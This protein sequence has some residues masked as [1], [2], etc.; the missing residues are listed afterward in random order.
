MLTTKFTKLNSDVMS[1]F[2]G[3]EGKS[4]SNEDAVEQQEAESSAAAS[5]ARSCVVCGSPDG[6]KSAFS[7]CS[8][9]GCPVVA[10]HKACM[11]SCKCGKAFCSEECAGDH[12]CEI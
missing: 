6:A 5:S 1:H 4:E 10:V 2:T 3:V 7:T 11:T 8:M 12:G 9:A